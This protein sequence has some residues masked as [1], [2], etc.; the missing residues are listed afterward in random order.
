MMADNENVDFTY[1]DVAIIEGAL[2][3]L[4]DSYSEAIESGDLSASDSR[5]T[6]KYVRQAK[7]ALKKVR[8]LFEE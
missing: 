8:L 1:D 5:E 7:S 3:S 4:I 6:R 2:L